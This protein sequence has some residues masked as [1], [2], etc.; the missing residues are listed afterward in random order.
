MELKRVFRYVTVLLG[1]M[2]L[3][4]TVASAQQSTP[5]QRPRSGER[6]AANRP[7][8]QEVTKDELAGIIKR[9]VERQAAFQ[10]GKFV[11][12][13]REGNK[14]LALDLQKVRDERLTKTGETS[15]VMCAEFKSTEGKLYDLDFFM[16]SEGRRRP[17][18]TEIAIHKAEGKERYSWVEEN[19]IW[20][21]K[22]LT[23][24][25]TPAEKPPAKS[26]P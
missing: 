18:V 4:G 20:K 23:P 14:A 24:A 11:F 3:A 5:R 8:G 21:K 15:Y 6:K 9:F 2:L 13:D 1:L 10:G 22:T 17:R 26:T 7:A 25:A 19:G 12:Y 16:V